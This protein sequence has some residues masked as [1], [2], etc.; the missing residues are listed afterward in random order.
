[1]IIGN[2]QGWK[3]EWTTTEPI[4]TADEGSFKMRFRTTRGM[5][6][7]VAEA[8]KFVLGG[9]IKSMEIESKL[10]EHCCAN[11]DSVLID[12]PSP[13]KNL[14]TCRYYSL[15]E[16]NALMKRILDIPL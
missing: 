6:E 9:D 2:R 8:T 11:I 10:A 15:S 5:G 12:L 7:A 1:M 14:S 4:L 16:K 13:L 3:A